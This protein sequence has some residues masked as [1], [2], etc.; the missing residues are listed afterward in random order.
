MEE[1]IPIPV[2][3]REGVIF[4]AT[5]VPWFLTDGVTWTPTPE[6]VE[7]AE[8][9]LQVYLTT[10]IP[11][12]CPTHLR[13]GAG[14]RIAARLD[15]YARQYFGVSR[16][17][18]RYLYFNCFTARHPFKWRTRLLFAFGGGESYFHLLY[19]PEAEEFSELPINGEA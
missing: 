3:G 13:P 4:P 1:V 6:D 16:R 18:R 11:I 15:Y 9:R 8:H 10:A 17:G 5:Q 7:Q 19:D 2:P 12:R 14:Q